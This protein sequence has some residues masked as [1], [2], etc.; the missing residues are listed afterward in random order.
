MSPHRII[1]LTVPGIIGADLALQV[2][3]GRVRTFQYGN[4]VFTLGSKGEIHMYSLK[5]GAKLRSYAKRVMREIW[6][7]TNIQELRTVATSKGVQ[8]MLNYLG[9][10]CVH[11]YVYTVRKPK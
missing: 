3:R 9:W 5:A 4:T 2:K 1:E 8:R 10:T 7:D 11:P 6:R